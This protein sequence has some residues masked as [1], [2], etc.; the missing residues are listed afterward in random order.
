MSKSEVAYPGYSGK[1]AAHFQ[2]PP[3]YAPKDG[4]WPDLNAADHIA[5]G[6]PVGPQEELFRRT[7][8]DIWN[9]DAEL[10][11]RVEKAGF[12]IWRGQRDT[13]P[14]AYTR[15]GAF[16]FD[17]GACKAVINGDIKIEQWFISHFTDSHVFLNGERERQYDLVVLATG[18]SNTVESV[19]TGYGRCD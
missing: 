5:H 13:G 19:A 2:H 8:Q 6:L 1:A 7:A 3:L 14:L 17:A 12:K 18:F 15:N 4:K 11:A 10:F 16:Y 9:A